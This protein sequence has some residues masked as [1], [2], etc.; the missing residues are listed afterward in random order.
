MDGGGGYSAKNGA[1]D[2]PL[3]RPSSTGSTI[4]VSFVLF[5]FFYF[6]TV[7]TYQEDFPMICETCLGPNPYVRMT[8]LPYGHKLC[9]ISNLPYQAFR[10]KAGPGGRQKET[11]I[12]YYI[13]FSSLLFTVNVIYISIAV[14]TERNICQTCLNDMKYG[15]PV[16]VRDSL[17]QKE[18]TTQISLPNSNVGQ[19]YFYE[20]QAQLSENDIGSTNMSLELA[21]APPS[22]QLDKFSRM[23]QVTEAK[24][25]IA[26]R[27]LPKLCSFWLNGAC[28]RVLRKTC[29][30][31]PCCGVYMFPEIASSSKLICDRLI[32]SLNTDGPAVVQK[33]MDT[34]TKQAIQQALK[35]NRDDAIRKLSLIHI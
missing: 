35:G 4:G 2:A 34:E 14:A 30:F 29:P 9:K 10:W 24:S 26:F 32:E 18:E 11:I 31:R 12:R 25:K 5:L 1:R 17:L 15:L 3:N 27:N 19:K 20:Q 6:I 8:K 23:L 28:S 7:F 21:N 33:S 13:H 16:G 22:R